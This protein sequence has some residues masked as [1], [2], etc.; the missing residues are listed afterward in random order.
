[1]T[2]A[3]IVDDSKLARMVVRKAL[4]ELRPDWKCIEASSATEAMEIVGLQPID[5]A[6]I[7]YN[8]GRQGSNS[9]VN[10]GTSN[11]SAGRNHHGECTGCDHRQDSHAEGYLH[12]QANRR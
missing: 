2:T 11:R 1:M 10:S 8:M 6:F 3:L 12:K 7:D 9:S 5:V 4:I